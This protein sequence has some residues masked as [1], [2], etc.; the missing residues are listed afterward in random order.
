MGSLEKLKKK[1]AANPQNIRFAD[2]TRVLRDL[3]YREV[4]VQGSHH[5][6]RPDGPGPS[7]LIVRPHGGKNL[8]SMVD[9]KKVITLLDAKE[10]DSED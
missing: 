7:I 6:F 10:T 1:L 3:G 4:R 2:L 8:C 5:I 9:V